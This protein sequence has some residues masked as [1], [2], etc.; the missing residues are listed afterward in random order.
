MKK[1]RKAVIPIQSN[2][3]V[4]IILTQEVAADFLVIS[5]FVQTYLASM[6][7]QAGK[8]APCP[9]DRTTQP[10]P[11]NY[12]VSQSVSMDSVQIDQPV[13]TLVDTP[14]DTP[15]RYP[16]LYHHVYDRQQ[17]IAD[18][19]VRALKGLIQ[20]YNCPALLDKEIELMPYQDDL[21]VG[22]VLLNGLMRT[23]PCEEEK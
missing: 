3:V 8:A 18:Q 19:F 13:P 7:Q 5:D 2:R 14:V 15:S 6:K 9:R 23:F 22:L 12:C 21:H 10:H 1:R 11:M 16:G 4:I 17:L 20:A